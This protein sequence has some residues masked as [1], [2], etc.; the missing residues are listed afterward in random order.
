MQEVMQLILTRTNLKAK[1]ETGNHKD[2]GSGRNKGSTTKGGYKP[3]EKKK[4]A[5]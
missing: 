4:T 1:Q 2:K 5:L 3:D